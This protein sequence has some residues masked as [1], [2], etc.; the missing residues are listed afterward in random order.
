MCKISSPLSY[1][2]TNCPTV[3]E[4]DRNGQGR[5]VKLKNERNSEGEQYVLLLIWCLD[6]DVCMAPTFHLHSLSQSFDTKQKRTVLYNLKFYFFHSDFFKMY[7]LLG[8]L[9]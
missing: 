2:L 8:A 6:Y 7:Y 1:I 3:G 5:T 9:M 4:R